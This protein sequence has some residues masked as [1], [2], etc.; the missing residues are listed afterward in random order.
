MTLTANHSAPAQ[1]IFCR[2]L[3]AILAFERA[4]DSSIC[5]Y[6]FNRVERLEREVAR[7]KE[8]LRRARGPVGAG[9]K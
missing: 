9:Q 4:M 3:G 2:A 5:D 6:E 1:G 7:L 8:E